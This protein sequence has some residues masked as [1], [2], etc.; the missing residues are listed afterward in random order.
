MCMCKTIIIEKKNM[1]VRGSGV[2]T[3]VDGPGNVRD[4]NNLN[5]VL[6]YE[7]LKNN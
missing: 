6:L 1:N 3:G 2:G 5:I 7:I 4:R